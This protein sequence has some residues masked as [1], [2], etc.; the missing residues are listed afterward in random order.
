MREELTLKIKQQPFEPR[1]VLQVGDEQLFGHVGN[2]DDK[3]VVARINDKGSYRI[4]ISDV[5]FFFVEKT[6][7]P[8]ESSKVSPG[9]NGGILARTLRAGAE[10]LGEHCGSVITELQYVSSV[11][12]PRRRT[13]NGQGRGL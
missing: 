13:T 2:L 7:E 4:D 8:Y 10:S 11:L 6:A 5:G 1:F 12:L 3:H 9:F